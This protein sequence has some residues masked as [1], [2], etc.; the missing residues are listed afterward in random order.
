ME[1]P[2][3]DQFPGGIRKSVVTILASWSALSK[4]GQNG[5]TGI[6]FPHG[7]DLDREFGHIWVSD[8]S[9]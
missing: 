3:V 1:R 8:G 4:V 2:S 7:P 9:N 6:K 5:S